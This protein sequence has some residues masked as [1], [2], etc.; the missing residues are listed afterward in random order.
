MIDTIGVCIK[1]FFGYV[2]VVIGLG[3]TGLLLSFLI[4]AIFIASVT[5]T[6]AKRKV[7]FNLPES[8]FIR[9]TFMDG[10]SNIPSKLSRMFIFSLSVVLLAS[11][12]ISSSDGA[13][14]LTRYVFQYNF[15][16]DNRQQLF[17]QVA[18]IDK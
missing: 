6:L 8:R 16:L 17:L 14:L 9:E 1:F 13:S 12:G 10:L 11:F 2:L 4:H 7:G 18:K 15:S 3:A 5:F